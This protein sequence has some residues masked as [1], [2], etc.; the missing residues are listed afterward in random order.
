MQ[1]EV[2]RSLPGL[3]GIFQKYR[4]EPPGE[5]FSRFFISVLV[6]LMLIVK[7]TRQVVSERRQAA[8]RELWHP[9]ALTL[10][11]LLIKVLLAGVV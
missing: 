9:T 7:P 8:G 1:N 3:I 6:L 10:H 4:E 2:V 11:A 5:S